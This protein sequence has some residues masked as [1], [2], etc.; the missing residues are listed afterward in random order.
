[1]ATKVFVRACNLQRLKTLPS[2]RK[3]TGIPESQSLNATS[4][5]MAKKM[6]NNSAARTHP[7]LVLFVIAKAVEASPPSITCP[8]MP[9]WN[10]RMRLMNF[11]GHPILAKIIHRP[12]LLTESKA[13]VRSI[14]TVKMSWCCSRHFSCICRALNI[15]SAVPLPD[16]NPH[17][18]SGMLLLLCY[19][20]GC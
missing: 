18:L 13:F 9:S 17:W 16:R 4:N 10:E 14:N 2:A 1:M 3:R 11:C 12:G 20:Q 6:L 5:I 7:C 8:I 19:M 15:M